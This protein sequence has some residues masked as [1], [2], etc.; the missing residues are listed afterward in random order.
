VKVYCASKSCHHR[1]WQAL[2]SAGVPISATWIDWSC[3][4]DEASAPTSEQWT[5]HW[6]KCIA[7]ARD[8]DVLLFVNFEGER[9]CGALIELGAALAAGRQVFVVTGA[10]WWSI[11]HNPRCRVFESIEKAIEA[12]MAM[13]AGE[14]ARAVALAV[15]QGVVATT[16]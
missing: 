1:W 14:Q 16:G 8:S 13:A 9:A 7:E 2:R 5:R 6:E 3:N 15:G 12:I 10:D 4:A 11:S